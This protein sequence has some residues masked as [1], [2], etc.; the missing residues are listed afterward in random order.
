MRE[1]GIQYLTLSM[2]ETFSW[3]CAE[4]PERAFASFSQIRGETQNRHWL[5][6]F[7]QL[8]LGN[9]EEA[10]K[11]I[12]AYDKRLASLPEVDRAVLLTLW[13][14]PAT[15][16][17][18]KD[19]A[20]FFPTLPSTL[21]GLPYP[22]TRIVYHPSVLP[23]QIKTELPLLADPPQKKPTTSSR[24]KEPPTVPEPPEEKYEDFDLHVAPD[25]HA[26]ARSKEG[27]AKARISTEMPTNLKLS[28]QLIEQRATS[29]DLLKEVGGV[30]YD[31]LFPGPIHTHLQQT[32]A[33]ARERNAKLRLRLRVEAGAIARLPL[34]F[35][36]RAIGGYFLATNAQTVFS[37][38]LN[39]PL[40]PERVRRREGPLHLLAIVADPIDQNV[41]LNPDEWETLLQEALA[42][43]IADGR[44]TLQ[45]VKRA[46]RK[47][48]RNALNDRKPDILQFV[49]HG[50]Y[51]NGK[52][53]LVLVDDG[54]DK[55]WLVD[56]EQF[57]N[58]FAGWSDR[59]GLICMATCESAKSDDPQAFLGIAP[60]LVERHGT[61]AVVAMQYPVLVKTAKVF[62][63]ELYANVAARKPV[64]WAVQSARNAISLD[65]GHNREFATPVLYMRAE[66]GNVF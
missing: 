28:F 41:R 18:E 6:A 25:G 34:E 5:H 13:D 49:G 66:D 53:H 48:I 12:A 58:L 45:T 27:E 16:L 63:D 20:Y 35:T 46:T 44:M 30:L 22:V 60:Q 64:D 59:L 56:D 19:L 14:R 9:V 50:I 36:Y 37:R 2:I 23:Q 38:Y 15:S 21:T 54:T 40:P 31:W 62:L 52:G 47:E 7:I 57:A 17:D 29:T 61:P 33:V 3:L 55:T 26:I 11:A 65:F 4:Q 10:K 39:L 8:Q 51:R 24:Q 42:K 32:E 1:S 43:P